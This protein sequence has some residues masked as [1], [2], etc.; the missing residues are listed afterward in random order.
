MEKGTPLIDIAIDYGPNGKEKTA[1]LWG[2][3]HGV[4]KH[5]VVHIEHFD[6]SAI[7]DIEHW[8]NQRWH[9]K[10]ALLDPTV[11]GVPTT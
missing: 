10:D 7:A 3:L 11:M 6:L 5:I 4:P 9:Q 2:C 8:L 1:T